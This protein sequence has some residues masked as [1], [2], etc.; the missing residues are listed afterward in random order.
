MSVEEKNSQIAVAY[1]LWSLKKGAG[2]K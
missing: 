1:T 2:G